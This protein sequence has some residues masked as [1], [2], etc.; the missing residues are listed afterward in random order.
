[1]T[2]TRRSGRVNNSRFVILPEGRVPNWASRVMRLCVDRLSADWLQTY[3]HEVITQTYIIPNEKPGQQ[4]AIGVVRQLHLSPRRFNQVDMGIDLIRAKRILMHLK[5]CAVDLILN[6]SALAL[7]ACLLG[8]CASA[9]RQV[10]QA[11]K[12][13]CMTIRGSQVIPVYPLTED[14]Q[15]GDIFLVQVPIG[16][17]MNRGW[18]KC[19]IAFCI[20]R[21]EDGSDAT[22]SEKPEGVVYRFVRNNPIGSFDTDGRMEVSACCAR[23]RENGGKT[24]V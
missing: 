8:G 17:T 22:P 9:E 13:W 23:R 2:A 24:A 10:Q 16:G 7:M 15:P 21:W 1:M 5:P 3:G 20:Q 6:A 18:I 19:A 11:A 12:D 4:G 14:I